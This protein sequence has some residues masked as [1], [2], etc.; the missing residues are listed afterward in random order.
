MSWKS[1]QLLERAI[2]SIRGRDYDRALAIL[3]QAIGDAPK[4]AE[5]WTLR[6]NVLLAQERFFDAL[7][8]YDR[9]LEVR[10][11]AADA[12]NNR[13]QALANLGRFDEAEA[14]FR[15]SVNIVESREPH[16]GLANMFATLMRLEEAAAEY[17]KIVEMDPSDHEA[18]FNLGVTLLGLGRWEEGFK[19]YWHRHLNQEYPPAARRNYPEWTGQQALAGKTILLYPEQGYGDEIMAARFAWLMASHRRGHL[20]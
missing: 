18:H 13:G 9:A 7:L 17:G 12:M 20:G 5:A 16:I 4:M 11:N 6:G 2:V 10:P 15:A 3:V 1:E 14:S 19:A 8:H